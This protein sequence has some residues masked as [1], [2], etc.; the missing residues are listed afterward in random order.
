MPARRVARCIVAC[1]AAL[2]ALGAVSLA[3][4]FGVSGA[5]VTN[6]AIVPG[7][8]VP[9]APFAHAPFSSGQ[10][11]T[12]TVPANSVF[13]SNENINVVECTALMS[14][15]GIPTDP[16]TCDG[17][18]INGGTIKPGSSGAISASYQLFSLPN[19]GL[20]EGSSG[21]AC[22]LTVACILYIGT[23]QGDFTQPHVWSP[24]F[25]IN[26]T[27]G[28]TG[29]NP[30]DGSAPSATAL[31]VSPSSP[32]MYGQPVTFTATVS[33]PAT[34]AGTPTGTV[35][36]LD[37]ST[38]LGSPVTLSGVTAA[39]TTSALPVGAAQSITAVYSGDTV[40][41]TS[42]SSALTYTVNTA[43]TTTV[44][45]VSPASPSVYGQSVT[46]TATV[47]P[48]APGTGTPT[49]TVTFADGGT[50]LGT[51]TLNG[52]GVATYTTT[53]LS[54]GSTHSITAAYGGDGNFASSATSA[55]LTYTVGQASTT[56]TLISSA[57]PSTAGA[58]VTFTDT[59]APVAPG[60]GTPTGSVTFKDNGTAQGTPVPLSSGVATYTT[61]ALPGGAN[62][63]TAVY[64]GDANFIA[65]T[66][67]TVNQQVQAPTSFTTTVNGGSSATVASG[68][69]ATLAESSIPAT[70]A[71]SVVFSYVSSSTTT[72][73]CTISL[74][75]AA[76]EPTS[77]TTATSLTPGT[78]SPIGATFT[79]AAGSSFNGSNSTNT[80]ALTVSKS[81]TTTV[82]SVSPSSPSVY[83]QSVTYTATVAPVAPATGTPTGTVTFADGSTTL[84]TGTLNGSGVATYTT[85]SLSVGSTHSITASYGGDGNFAASTST[86]LT[87]TVGQASTTS[88]LTSS[89][90]PSTT[91]ASVTFTDT[92]A[93]VAPGAGTPT[94]SVI[95]KDNGTTVGSV[96]PLTTSGVATYT[97]TTLPAGANAITAVYS[98][99]TNFIA[100]TS[101]AVNQQVQTPPPAP[102]ATPGYWTVASDGG[103]F[104]FGGAPFYGST[105]G[106]KLNEP[107]VG[108]ASTPDHKGYWLVA[109][110]GG[111]FAFG[112]AQFYGSTGGITLNRP[113]VGM[114]VTPDGGGY[115]LVASDG[116]IFAFGDAPYL[117]SGLGEV[118]APVV[119]I[120]SS[121][122]GG[123]WIA[124]SN[125]QA[126]NFGFAQNL[127]PDAPTFLGSPVVGIAATP[128]GGGYWLV[129]RAGGVFRFGTALS[130]GSTQ[131]MALNK[132]VVDMAPSH[133]GQGYW[134]VATDGGIFSFGDANF[135][136]STGD[137]ILNQPMIGM[138]SAS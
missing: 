59:V 128:G 40:F 33:T 49:G 135:Y 111:I 57:N 80:V 78:Y 67:S 95:F 76:G 22:S 136:G 75:G 100:S 9:T 50:T 83:G 39:L 101:S 73:L 26:P 18:T 87:Y 133:D 117:G 23:A 114:A 66:S 131:N 28:N 1:L 46:Y 85:T 82:L 19:S 105:G 58:S 81:N 97:T 2:S 126:Y 38:S 65:S 20:G 21:P 37:G 119:G 113:I 54:V 63:I 90:N 55:P 24:V 42:T 15:G 7:A 129:T 6:G 56:S 10:T 127:G 48:V 61:T 4:F 51:G 84:G 130:F 107:I 89:A 88:T 44:L 68:T 71:G 106:I 31:A 109:S 102:T 69:A 30:G 108:M 62:P 120:A 3:G 93:P 8:D 122:N 27:A 60:A 123:Y 45:N 52:S 25:Y 16:S 137:I 17:N 14:N 86:A 103:V 132:P 41:G 112:D 115:W 70:A 92:V 79:P 104:A 91:G 29:A 5:A 32:T 125:G 121:G 134:L 99:D 94:G 72:T 34:G 43:N 77:C 118:S 36:F 64:S 116:G 138:A 47:T 12:V 35:S 96:A 98:G 13:T 74:T 53:S 110:D 11:I 124:G